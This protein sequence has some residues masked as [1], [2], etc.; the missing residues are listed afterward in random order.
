V[1]PAFPTDNPAVKPIRL[2]QDVATGGIKCTVSGW[3]LLDEKENTTPQIL[4]FAIARLISYEECRSKYSNIP[5]ASIKPGM[6]CANNHRRGQAACYGDSGGPLQ[7]GGLLTGVMSGGGQKCA[8]TEHPDVY[9]DVAYYKK[10]INR[11]I[12][13]GKDEL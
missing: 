4:Q 2:R 9:T 13:K 8:S 11:Q 1:S 10:W 12:S 5:T 6:I 3:G 7:C